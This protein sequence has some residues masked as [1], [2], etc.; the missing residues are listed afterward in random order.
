M[1]TDRA[2]VASIRAPDSLL[3][4]IAYLG[5]ARAIMVCMNLVGTSRLAHALGATNFGINSFA[6]S[7]VAYFLVV[8]SLG[9]ETFITREIAHDP[10][11]LRR[12]VDSM[13]TMRLLLAAIIA[14]LLVASL[15]LLHLPP[16]SRTV[17]LIQGISLF[18]TAIGLSC[19]YQGLQRMR[20]VA[21]REF[22]GSLMNMV[23]ILWLVHTPDDVVL[24]ASVT[25]ATVVLTNLPLLVQYT[26]DFGIPR[27]CLPRAEDWQMA[28]RSMTY[29]WSVLMISV[30]Y[31]IHIVLLGLLRS[32][33]DVGL[34]SAGWKLFNFAVVV[35]NLLS[36]LFLPRIANLT[37]RPAER[38]QMT[39]IYMQTIIVCVVPIT[40]FGCALIP[41][42]LMLLFG[43]T[44]LP[45]STSV[46]LLLANG[47]VVALNIG[48]G[49][50]LTAV[51]R[52]K[53]LLRVLAIG[54][55]GGILLNLAL[56]PRLG[57]EGAALAT[58]LDE[59]MILGLLIRDRPEVSIPLA[60]GFLLRCLLSA[61]PAAF[62]V[63]LVAGLPLIE[64]SDLAAVA[65]GGATG[66]MIYLLILR[67]M[68]IDLRQFA[69]G[70]RSLN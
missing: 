66:G 69:L 68:R 33:T 53:S 60:S 18:S 3:S 13:I 59:M 35:P 17:V 43:P 4:G 37:A 12:L 16:L 45:A 50:P 31:N 28:N 51:G 63:H 46:A 56:I 22:L 65:V 7:Y 64:H 39:G 54:A 19:V 30:T 62:A 27:I 6:V 49:I 40:L 57:S 29:F 58:L 9:Y 70:L 41:Q 61:A 5:S 52:Q 25:A 10:S 21:T 20:V 32:N 38:A 67:I 2:S 24:A 42:I 36:A 26:R 14:V 23:G 48:L 44:Y 47:L 8:A 1:T 34:F 55:I 11:R 15:L